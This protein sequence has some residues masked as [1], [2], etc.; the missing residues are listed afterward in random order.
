MIVDVL[1]NNKS[2]F[3]YPKLWVV[4]FNNKPFWWFRY[5]TWIKNSRCS[6]VYFSNF[7]LFTKSSF[8]V[9]FNTKKKLNIVYLCLVF[10]SFFKG[11][12]FYYLASSLENILE[13]SS[14]FSVLDIFAFILPFFSS[15]NCFSSSCRCLSDSSLALAASSFSNIS[16]GLRILS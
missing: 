13:S 7:L 3:F 11:C 5:K 12:N 14:A 10:F 9:H 6:F 16:R 15:F 1:I 2:M 8:I 4:N